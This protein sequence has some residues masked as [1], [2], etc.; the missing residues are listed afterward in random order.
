MQH[1]PL[2]QAHVDL[3]AR[4]VDFGG[5]SM[6]ISYGSQISEHHTVRRGAGVFD[7]SHM[8]ILDFKGTEVGSFLRRVLANDVSKLQSEGQ[9]LYSCMLRED[10]GILDDLIVY[11]FGRERFRIISNAATCTKDLAWFREVASGTAVEI[12]QRKDL[13][14]LAVQGPRAREIV[15]KSISHSKKCLALGPFFSTQVGN[16]MVARTGYTGEDGFEVI[17]PA[18]NVCGFWEVLLKHGVVPCGLGSRDTLR[19]EAGLNLYGADM[20]ESVSPL[21]CGLKWTV[22]LGEE[23]D[24]IG[25]QA[26]YRELKVG[27]KD[28]QVGLI[29]NGKGVLRTGYSVRTVFG[30]GTLTSG[31]YSPTLGCSIAFARVPVQSE[32][33]CEVEIRGRWHDARI[34]KPPFVRHGKIE[35][36]MLQGET[37]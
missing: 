8:T 26:L 18:K 35:V 17:L 5:W 9:A 2:Y 16:Y 12:D 7:V 15:A 27:L 3:G 22:A 24:F 30:S 14:M 32:R 20:D 28:K 11:W 37:A 25:R 6:P 23:R 13:A 33:A 31:S 1:T 4:M 36:D 21:R 34:V 29:L 10:G 19:L